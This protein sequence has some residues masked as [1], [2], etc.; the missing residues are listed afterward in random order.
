[1]KRRGPHSALLSERDLHERLCCSLMEV[2]IATVERDRRLECM[3]LENRHQPDRKYSPLRRRVLGLFL[4]G[5]VVTGVVLTR[6]ILVSLFEAINN[7]VKRR[8]K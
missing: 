7:G 8:K 1:M 4:V 6:Q 2:R 3:Q 5:I